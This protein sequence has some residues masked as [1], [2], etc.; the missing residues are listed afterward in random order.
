MA[1][2]GTAPSAWADETKREAQEISGA[3]RFHM[4][5]GD[6]SAADDCERVTQEVLDAFGRIDVLVNNAGARTEY[7]GAPFW[8]VAAD[9]WGRIVR[10]N[11]DSVF[12]MSRCVIPAMIERRLGKIINVSTNARTM[13]KPSFTPYGPS[14]AFVEACTRA[15]AEELEGTDV[16]VNALLPGGA[17]DTSGDVGDGKP[18]KASSRPASVMVEPLLWLAADE[19]N[20]FSGVRLVADRWD[21]KLGLTDRIAAAREDGAVAPGIM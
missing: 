19:S 3:G 16:T 8:R 2:I 14:K 15:W 10:T 17:V 11:C 9:E 5:F 21:V 7:P 6:V 20:G 4:T 1:A 12:L 18:A 13:A